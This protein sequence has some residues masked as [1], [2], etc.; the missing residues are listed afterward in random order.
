MSNVLQRLWIKSLNYICAVCL[1]TKYLHA[2]EPALNSFG[3]CPFYGGDSDLSCVVY[4]LFVVA[5]I[6]SEVFVVGHC[7]VVLGV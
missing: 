1:T 5:H 7:G 6:V 2:F 3:C 4:S